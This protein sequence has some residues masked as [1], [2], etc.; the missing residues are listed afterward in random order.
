MVCSYN[1]KRYFIVIFNSHAKTEPI[2]GELLP[3]LLLSQRAGK[4]AWDVT[5]RDPKS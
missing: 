3:S 2:V 4:G 5:G 1:S